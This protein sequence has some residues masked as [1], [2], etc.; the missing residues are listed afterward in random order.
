MTQ[1]RRDLA[2][3]HLRRMTSVVIDD[4]PTY[5]VDVCDLRA[6][7]VPTRS[8]TLLD[9][10]EQSQLALWLCRAPKVGT[11]YLGVSR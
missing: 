6:P 3:T 4:E 8:E 7:T 9:A 2:L 1:K 5:P 10:F 11:R